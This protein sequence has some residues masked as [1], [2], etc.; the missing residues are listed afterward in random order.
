MSNELGA[1]AVA[2]I[3]MVVNDIEKTGQ[4]FA[5]F[6]GVEKPPV[7]GSGPDEIVQA[8]VNGERSTASCKM[9]FFETGNVQLELIEPDEQP[10]VW[11]DILN[12]KG[13]G[14]H[15][16]AFQVKDAKGQMKTLAS[17]GHK[18]LQ[19]G[20]YGDGSGMYAYIDR[21]DDLNLIIELLESFE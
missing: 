18:T 17:K 8:E 11:R 3:G 10:S 1:T 16:I 19:S 20:N 5:D 7:M 13:P 4:F 14:L 12:E 15:H 6:F 9:M 21:R 2:Q